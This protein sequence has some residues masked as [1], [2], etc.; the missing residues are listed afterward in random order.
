[1]MMQDIS[2]QTGE[3]NGHPT[4]SFWDLTR[5]GRAAR[6]PLLS[7]GLRK[8]E[9]ILELMGSQDLTEQL[10]AWVLG[11]GGEVPEWLSRSLERRVK[12]AENGGHLEGSHPN[13][14]DPLPVREVLPTTPLPRPSQVPEQ[15]EAAQTPPE[16][17]KPAKNDFAQLMRRISQAPRNGA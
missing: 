16:P 12:N 8:A 5:R 11:E 2:I 1:M 10:A 3:Y 15:V 6:Y 14:D 4:I 9:F 13:A 17:Q 7:V